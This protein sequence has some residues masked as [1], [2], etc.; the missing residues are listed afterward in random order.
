MGESRELKDR[1]RN[2][3]LEII[4]LVDALPRGLVTDTLGRQLVRAGTSVG[5]NYRAASRARSAAEFIS[6]MHT[7]QEEADETQY[8]LDLLY[9]SKR[10]NEIVFTRLMREAGELTAIFTSSEKTARLNQRRGR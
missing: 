9:N 6:K 1:T 3:A 2:F 4:K 10:I 8:W 7:V 5:A